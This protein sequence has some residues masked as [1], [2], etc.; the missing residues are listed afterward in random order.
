MDGPPGRGV[1]MQT[2]N[3]RTIIYEKFLLRPLRVPLTSSWAALTLEIKPYTIPLKLL[4]LASYVL[5]GS[6]RFRT[7]VSH[8]SKMR[9]RTL[10]HGSFLPAIPIATF[11]IKVDVARN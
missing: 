6:V 2:R 11:G 10:A 1:F 3:P 9:H 8:G 4:Q 7:Y 5:Q